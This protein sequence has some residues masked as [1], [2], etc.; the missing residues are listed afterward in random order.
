MSEP[1]VTI[2][3]AIRR[4]RL[5]FAPALL[6]TAVWVAVGVVNLGLASVDG[7]HSVRA[8]AGSL[9]S[10]CGIPLSLGLYAA[11]RRGKAMPRWASRTLT[12]VLV[13]LAGTV[14]WIAN[15]SFQAWAG[16]HA[17]VGHL[18]T[19][20]FMQT[21]MNWLY[22]TALVVLQVAVSGLFDSS[23]ALRE[24]ERQLHEARL[25]ALRLQLNPHFLFNTLNAIATLA[26]ESGAREAEQMITRLAAFLRTSLESEPTEQVPLSVELETVQAYL[27]VE[28]VRYGDRLDVRY[29]CEAGLTDALVP[30]FILQPLVE[31]ALKYA[32]APSLGVVT[33]TVSASFVGTTLLV[34]IDD[35]GSG[36]SLAASSG[37]GLGLRNVAARL[38]AMY[39]ADASIDAGPRGR[40]YRA[41]LRLPLRWHAG[42]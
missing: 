3:A 15:T 40:G 9:T 30:N 20:W 33:I 11:M 41:A 38:E 37:T 29:A 7:L 35:S 16:G 36:R 18:P 6:I 22:F 17:P 2:P 42:A 12:V 21:H 31:N 28:A 39:G 34:A 5:S 23:N 26:A 13:P 24:R 25:S 27:A 32:V 19:D 14:L 1:L 4:N 8:I 10:L